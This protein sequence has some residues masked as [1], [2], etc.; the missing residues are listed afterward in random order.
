[1]VRLMAVSTLLTLGWTSR[2][3]WIVSTIV[4]G[5]SVIFF[6]SPRAWVFEVTR[7]LSCCWYLE[8]PLLELVVP[9]LLLRLCTS[10]VVFISVVRRQR[11]NFEIPMF[12]VFYMFY[13]YMLLTFDVHFTHGRIWQCNTCICIYVHMCVYVYEYMLY[14]IMWLQEKLDWREDLVYFLYWINK[15]N[16]QMKYLAGWRGR[17]TL[18]RQAVALIWSDVVVGWRSG[19]PTSQMAY[20]LYLAYLY[21]PNFKH[22]LQ[23]ILLV[24]KMI[25]WKIDFFL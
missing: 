13:V 4:R 8:W 24:E 23:K 14:T 25:G 21:L 18:R 15:I 19:R 16:K 11:V 9:L 12:W 17:V 5:L 7:W 1:M 3:C 2:M 10:L 22:R 20:D 6:V